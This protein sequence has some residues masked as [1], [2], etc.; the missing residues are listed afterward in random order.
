MAGRVPGPEVGRIAAGRLLDSVGTVEA[1]MIGP[2]LMGLLDPVLD[3]AERARLGEYA[4]E[5]LTEVKA[6]AAAL[7]ARLR[8]GEGVGRIAGEALEAD[9][10]FV[11]PRRMM[12]ALFGA[13]GAHAARLGP[14]GFRS[15][16]D[17]A[18]GLAARLGEADREL[19]GAGLVSTARGLIEAGRAGDC[20]VLMDALVS[21]PE[22][23]VDAALDPELARAVLGADSGDLAAA[24]RAL[25]CSLDIPPPR[26]EGYSAESWAERVNP[27]HIRRLTG[28]VRVIA[29]SPVSL[30]E[31]VAHVGASLFVGGV[32][33][34]DD[35]IFQ[36]E[37]TALLNS[38]TLREEFHLCY[39]LLGRLPVFHAE[40]GASGRVRDLTTELDAWGNDGV[41]YFLRK[42][43]HVNA[44]NLNVGL[45][46]AVIR[47]WATGDADALGAHLPEDIRPEPEAIARSHA[48]MGPM[49][50]AMSAMA[51]GKVSFEPLARATDAEI[52]AASVGVADEEHG[53]K[54]RLLLKA[55]REIVAKYTRLHADGN[56]GRTLAALADECAEYRR[57]MDD[58]A[59]HEPEESLYY[60]RHI[61]FGIPSVIGT[62]RERKFDAFG[63]MLRTEERVR[64]M[65]EEAVGRVRSGTEGADAAEIEG[66]LRGLRPVA[67]LM[68]LH[69][70]ACPGAEA[71]VEMIEHNRLRLSQVLD[72][73]R[74]WQEDLTWIMEGVYRAFGPAMDALVA[75]MDSDARVERYRSADG[76][77]MTDRLVRD[78]MAATL[79]LD[80]TD[81]LLNAFA[82]CIGGLVG[83]GRDWHVC[84]GREG[85]LVSRFNLHTIRDEDAARYA[86]ALGAKARN[87]VR[88][89]GAGLPVPPA[90]TLAASSD[91]PPDVRDP[92]FIGLVRSAVGELEA[93]TGRRLG[94][95]SRPLVLAIRSGSVVSMPGVLDSVLY[96]G[97]GG[98]VHEGLAAEGGQRYAADSRRRLMEHYAEVV[99]GL[100]P[101]GFQRARE[102]LCHE[103]GVNDVRELDAAGLGRLCD[104]YARQMAGAG[105]AIPEEPF[106]QVLWSVWAVYASWH[107]ER[108]RAYRRAMGIS[109]HWGSA[110]TLMPMVAANAPGGGAIVMFTSRPF[111]PGSGPRGEVSAGGTGDDVVYGRQINRPLSA[112]QGGEGRSFEEAEPLIYSAVRDLAA[113]V[114]RAM[115]GQPQEV[116]AAY[117]ESAVYILQARRVQLQHGLM[118]RFHEDCR[119]DSKVV[120]RG[121]GVHAGALSGVAV[122]S[123]DPARIREIREASPGEPLI[124]VRPETSTDD[125]GLM[126]LVDGILTARGGIASH[127]SVLAQKFGL[128]AVVGCAALSVE[129]GRAEVGGYALADGV[130]LS[131]D[132]NTGLVYGGLCGLTVPER[133]W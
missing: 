76:P 54:A 118:E 46:E 112:V 4:E 100:D 24:Y 101:E 130:P 40:V 93:Y 36:R 44:S 77:V 14:E 3:E 68:R 59:V 113:L 16:V 95:A 96:A 29:A 72:L 88:L 89:I 124:L 19:L 83:E 51:G 55:Y 104:R 30:P 73:V 120:A 18:L 102:G 114:E 106:D 67:A 125:V 74:E 91:E 26:V 123:A 22:G 21:A 5:R 90:V 64:V 23:L 86:P 94:D 127:A 92:S 84:P 66:W 105:L 45:A 43:V 126:G 121:V 63:A 98:H 42:Q 132:G 49:L 31:V 119:M 69:G 1:A 48:A 8:A 62:Y 12:D 70:L 13:M 87:L 109:K 128:V 65:L 58:P 122:V 110:V 79:G 9:P 11:E 6:R 20:R 129:H 41:L 56:V 15:T 81:R 27:L 82:V 78:V 115:S 33:I 53:A 107:G 25:L 133:T 37:A 117:R 35:R 47:A 108:A 32:H 99:F 116:E 131:I 50:E 60:K 34:P 39:L 111:H 97:V 10:G 57:V 38:V 2:G 28:F 80:E 85:A 17:G 52:D 61:A 75:R 103:V 7:A 71:A